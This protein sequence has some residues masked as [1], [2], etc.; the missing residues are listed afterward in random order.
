MINGP[1][2][3]VTAWVYNKPFDDAAISRS[4]IQNL[5][6]F[7]TIIPNDYY[8]RALGKEAK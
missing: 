7:S 3:S 2:K 6:I 8:G 4:A 5:I 1:Y